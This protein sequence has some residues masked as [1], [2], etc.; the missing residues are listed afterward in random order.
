LALTNTSSSGR[1]SIRRAALAAQLMKQ[2]GDI[3]DGDRGDPPT[4]ERGQEVAV[5]L[6]AVS[7]GRARM[8]LAGRD[9]G[10]ASSRCERPSSRLLF[11]EALTLRPVEGS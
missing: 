6:V 9:L 2:L 11:A 1:R 10:R 5:E 8:T 7:L 3:V 4:P